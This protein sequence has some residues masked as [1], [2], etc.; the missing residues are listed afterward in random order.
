M[1][2]SLPTD[3]VQEAMYIITDAAARQ[4]RHLAQ[5][6]GLQPLDIARIENSLPAGRNRE[7]CMQALYRY[8]I[9]HTESSLPAG[10]NREK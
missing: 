4:W 10:W 3:K 7:K 2:F 9:A 6:L 5:R 8:D 1:L